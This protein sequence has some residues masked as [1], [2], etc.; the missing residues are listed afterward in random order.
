MALRYE[1]QKF[2]LFNPKNPSSPSSSW[3]HFESTQKNTPAVKI[4]GS[5]THP[6]IGGSNRGFLG[7]DLL[8]E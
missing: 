2:D 5:F 1:P 3:R 7:K 4:T 6:S 8:T